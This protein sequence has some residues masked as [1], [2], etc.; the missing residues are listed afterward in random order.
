MIQ[1][2]KKEKKRLDYM[3]AW[4]DRY[5]ERLQERLAGR[6]EENELLTALLFC[7][8]AGKS[9]SSEACDAYI[10]AESLRKALNAWQCKVV[11]E[12]GGYR[13]HFSIKESADDGEAAES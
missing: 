10:A 6:E 7:T 11:R 2:K 1:A 8:L 3:I 4:R 9:E 12:E 13:L 5:I